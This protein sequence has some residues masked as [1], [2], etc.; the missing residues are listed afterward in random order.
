MTVWDSLIRGAAHT[1][2][3]EASAQHNQYCENEKDDHE[4]GRAVEAYKEKEEDKDN[5]KLEPEEKDEE[6][7]KENDRSSVEEE[8]EQ[9][10]EKRDENHD[11]DEEEEEGDDEKDDKSPLS[12]AEQDADEETLAEENILAGNRGTKH[13]CALKENTSA[14]DAPRKK[15]KKRDDAIN[16]E[17]PTT[18][19]LPMFAEGGTPQPKREF[20]KRPS[21]DPSAFET[22]VKAKVRKES[23]AF[24]CMAD[25]E[26]EAHGSKPDCSLATATGHGSKPATSSTVTSTTFTRDAPAKRNQKKEQEAEEEDKELQAE[27]LCAQAHLQKCLKKSRLHGSSGR[28]RD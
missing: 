12:M 8:E 10:A 4:G 3:G 24:K 18:A 21:E 20:R 17:V 9:Q 25:A 23:R 7:Q 14:E 26:T 19:P 27:L 6:M 2:D 5:K 13:S 15:V 16:K 11:K 28:E 1:L 22:P